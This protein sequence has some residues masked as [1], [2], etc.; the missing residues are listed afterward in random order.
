[1][2]LYLEAEFELHFS[3]RTANPHDITCTVNSCAQSFLMLWEFIGF[4]ICAISPWLIATEEAK[5]N[6]IIIISC[7]AD[8]TGFEHWSLKEHYFEPDSVICSIPAGFKTKFFFRLLH[9]MKL[10]E[11]SSYLVTRLEY[12]FNFTDIHIN[13]FKYSSKM[14]HYCTFFINKDYLMA[15]KQNLK[16]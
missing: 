10:G 9:E 2:K 8:W 16:Y 5:E 12:I 14:V 6:C 7:K 11:S 1:M 13:C 3:C 4:N 15:N